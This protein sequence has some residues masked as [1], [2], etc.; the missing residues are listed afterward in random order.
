MAD[1]F[2]D[3]LHGEEIPTIYSLPEFDLAIISLMKKDPTIS[4][5]AIVSVLNAL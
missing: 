5:T 3:P 4:R 1:P 2:L